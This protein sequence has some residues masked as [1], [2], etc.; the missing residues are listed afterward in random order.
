MA[1]ATAR[2]DSVMGIEYA[3]VHATICYMVQIQIYRFFV[4]IVIEHSY[5]H[6]V[7]TRLV[8]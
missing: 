5:L 8:D 2:G 7:E 6:S 4:M 3:P 1:T